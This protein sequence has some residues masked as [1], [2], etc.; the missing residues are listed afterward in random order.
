MSSVWRTAGV[1][2]A[3]LQQFRRGPQQMTVRNSGGVQHYRQPPPIAKNQ[4]F[5]ANLLGG[6]MWFWILWHTWHTP[7]AILGHFPWPDASAWTDEELGI[8]PDD[9]E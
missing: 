6:F 5:N 2:R 4:I 9:E 3:G 1:L 7:D 8:P